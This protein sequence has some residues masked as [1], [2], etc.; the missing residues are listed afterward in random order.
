MYR[1][2]VVSDAAYTA[3]VADD[4]VYHIFSNQKLFI[5]LLQQWATSYGDR[6]II[7]QVQVWNLELPYKNSNKLK[8]KAIK[9][10]SSI[11]SK[12]NDDDEDQITSEIVVYMTLTRLTLWV[13]DQP[14]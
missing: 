14:L 7:Q 1:M 13:S 5:H 8:K 12:Y 11:D 6:D 3:H 4:D 2:V 10:K 9:R